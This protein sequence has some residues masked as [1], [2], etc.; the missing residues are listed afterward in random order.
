MSLTYIYRKAFQLE[1]EVALSRKALN[2][3][4]DYFEY[5]C[6]SKQD[7]ARVYEILEEYAKEMFA[8][9]DQM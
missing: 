6:E 1:Q 7:R 2:K 5:S 3:I 9:R 8:L 4:D